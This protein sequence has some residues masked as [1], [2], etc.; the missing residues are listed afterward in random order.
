ME[1]SDIIYVVFLGICCWLSLH[2]DSGDGGGGKRS[3]SRAAC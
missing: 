2:W 3:R 1:F